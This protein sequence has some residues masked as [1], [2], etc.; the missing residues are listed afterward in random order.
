MIFHADMIEAILAGRKTRTTR[1]T[2]ERYCFYRVGHDYAICSGRGE[3]QI[4]R[5]LVTGIMYCENY[6]VA[7][8][9]PDH[10]KREGFASADAFCERWE[11]MYA[12]DEG[13]REGPVWVIDFERVKRA[14]NGA[15]NTSE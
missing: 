15:K 10:A 7:S 6:Q 5:V 3:R 14:G 9:L 1:L 2:R 8:A 4:A 13:R 11:K 12:K